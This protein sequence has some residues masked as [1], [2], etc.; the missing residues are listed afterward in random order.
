VE[1][2]YTDRLYSVSSDVSRLSGNLW[3]ESEFQNILEKFQMPR[4]SD[5]NYFAENA[6]FVAPRKCCKPCP[7]HS[8]GEYG[9]RDFLQICVS[10]EWDNTWNIL[11]ILYY[12]ETQHMHI[13][14]TF[15]NMCSITYDIFSTWY[16]IYTIYPIH[17]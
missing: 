14:N 2:Q 15:K 16:Y 4:Q 17:R 11:R 13:C 9:S 10:Y 3:R 1:T 6:R 12:N 7:L 8:W 5:L